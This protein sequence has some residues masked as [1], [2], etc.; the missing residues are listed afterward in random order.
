MSLFQIEG[1]NACIYTCHYEG[2]QMEQSSIVL[3]Q[4]EVAEFLKSPLVTVEV[5]VYY[6]TVTL[7]S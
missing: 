5:S 1:L 7:L 6:T 2:F 4:T 3:L